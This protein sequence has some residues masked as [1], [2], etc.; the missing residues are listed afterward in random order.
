LKRIVSLLSSAVIA[1]AGLVAIP[2]VTAAP[3]H[4]DSNACLNVLRSANYLWT[5]PRV[6]ACYEGAKGFW[7]FNTCVAGM[8]AAGVPTAIAQR[9]CEAAYS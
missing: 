4:A 9:A 3:A 7:H 1:S 8:E 5:E 2:I 6:K